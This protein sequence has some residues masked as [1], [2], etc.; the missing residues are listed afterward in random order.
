MKKCPFYL[1]ISSSAR[2]YSVTL[3]KKNIAYVKRRWI[4]FLPTNMSE[5]VLIC[6]LTKRINKQIWNSFVLLHTLRLQSKYSI[7]ISILIEI[8][9]FA[10][11][12]HTFLHF[13][14]CIFPLKDSTN[15]KSIMKII[16]K[17]N[18]IWT[19]WEAKKKMWIKNFLSSFFLFNIL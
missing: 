18:W 17:F 19:V 14:F 6:C 3:K 2:S 4:I 15:I 8:S 12:I 16:T 1:F 5:L 11:F 9:V 7:R 13:D 10:R